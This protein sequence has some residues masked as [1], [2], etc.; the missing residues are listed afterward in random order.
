MRAGTEHF[1]AGHAPLPHT[2]TPQNPRDAR[3]FDGDGDAARADRLLDG[4]RDLCRE[5][6]LD[7]E[8]L[9]EAVRESRELR[10]ADDAARR[11][12][13][14]V[15]AAEKGQH[16]VL[17]H[18][19]ALDVAND[20]HLFRGGLE[21]RVGHDLRGLERLARRAGEERLGHAGGGLHEALAQR[22]LAEALRGER[23]GGGA[24]GGKGKG[25]GDTVGGARG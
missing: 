25:K 14:D 6:L 9:R 11:E 23:G 19:L 24:R 13:A 22:V 12:L 3:R 17:A 4:F 2:P 5:P 21:E 8:A 1:S 10:E 20:D 7:L 16:V 18:A 15:D